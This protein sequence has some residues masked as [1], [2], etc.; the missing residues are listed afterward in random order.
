MGLAI[1]SQNLPEHHSEMGSICSGPV[2]IQTHTPT[3]SIFRLET[4]S[5][6]SSDQCLPSSVAIKDKL[7][8]PSMGSN[9]E[10]VIRNQ[11]PTSRSSDCS[12]SLEESVLVSS[13]AIPTIQ[14][15]PP[16]NNPTRSTAVQESL[17]SPFQPQE[18]QLAIWPTSEVL[19]SIK[20]FKTSFRTSP[21]IMERHVHKGTHSFTSGNVDLHNRTEIPFLVL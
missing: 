11:P 14:L 18:V 19:S 12:S 4:R 2:C 3:A 6:G 15:S 7:C 17:P 16:H 5:P 8:K 9:I 13:S 20:V 21:G 10:G 1:T